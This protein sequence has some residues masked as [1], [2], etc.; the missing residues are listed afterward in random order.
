M[1]TIWHPTSGFFNIQPK[2]IRNNECVSCWIT[3][4]NS[5]HDTEFQEDG[6]LGPFISESIM[7]NVV[8]L[9]PEKDVEHL[10]EWEKDEGQERRREIKWNQELSQAPQGHPWPLSRDIE[11]YEQYVISSQPT[12]NKWDSLWPKG[13]TIELNQFYQGLYFFYLFNYLFRNW[14]FQL[15]IIF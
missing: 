11:R 4:G 2:I 7:S 12:N 10:A 15:F 3:T 8:L 9:R 5:S 1:T 6:A 14:P 13:I